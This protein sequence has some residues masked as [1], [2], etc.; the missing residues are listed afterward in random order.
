MCI[1]NGKPQRTGKAERRE[2]T[3]SSAPGQRTRRGE[4]KVVFDGEGI[5]YETVNGRNIRPPFLAIAVLWEI[6][7]NLV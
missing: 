5:N 2:V 3:Q 6:A 7:R 1:S 4:G